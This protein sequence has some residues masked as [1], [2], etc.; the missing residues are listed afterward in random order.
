MSP[1]GAAFSSRAFD[2]DEDDDDDVLQ[3][4]SE[5]L[6]LAGYGRIREEDEDSD[7]DG[8][9]DE[10]DESL[11]R[12]IHPCLKS[13]QRRN[14]EIPAARECHVNLGGVCLFILGGAVLEFWKCSSQT[15]VLHWG[16]PA[17][18]QHD[19]LSGRPAI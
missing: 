8:S 10:I 19:G 13:V 16:P 1:R 2:D 12:Q 7:D 3:P 6:I 9:D 4:K 14:G 11:V 5:M 15:A 18:V 17:P